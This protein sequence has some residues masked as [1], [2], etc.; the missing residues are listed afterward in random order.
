MHQSCNQQPPEKLFA[1][2]AN[3]RHTLRT[4][5]HSRGLFLTQWMGLTRAVSA[6]GIH[7]AFA[8]HASFRATTPDAC[9]STD[10][11]SRVCQSPT[12]ER[13]RPQ[14]ALVFDILSNCDCKQTGC[15]VC[16]TA[17][18][19]ATQPASRP[20]SHVACAVSDPWKVRRMGCIGKQSAWDCR[21]PWEDMS[22]RNGRVEMIE[23]G[24]TLPANKLVCCH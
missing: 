24:C 2:S 7:A 19:S 13:R 18:P 3:Q 1:V 16:Q 23:T 15:R 9:V 17:F 4:S 11:V 22:G 20:V 12:A 8:R 21:G 6:A 14:A 10:R 5:Q